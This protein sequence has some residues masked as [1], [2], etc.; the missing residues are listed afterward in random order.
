MTTSSAEKTKS[1]ID[2]LLSFEIFLIYRVK[3]SYFII[4]SASVLGFYRSR[5]MLYQ[6]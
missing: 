5:K 6:L 2:T 1:Y 3:F 4:L